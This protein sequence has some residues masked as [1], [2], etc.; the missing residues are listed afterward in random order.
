[1]MAVIAMFGDSAGVIYLSGDGRSKMTYAGGKAGA[2]VYQQIINQIPPHE[3]Y[4]EPFLGGG[5]VL[6]A[7]KR[8]ACSI[9]LDVDAAVVERWSRLN[10]DLVFGPRVPGLTVITG[11]AISYLQNQRCG[12]ETFVYCDPPYLF[13]V[14]SSK[15]RIYTHEFGDV[16]QHEKLL[17]VL[18]SLPCMVAVS[19]YWSSLYESSLPATEGWRSIS[20]NAK[21]RAGVAREWLWMNYPE[22][23][24]LHDYSYLGQNFRE[25]EKIT[26]QKK[27]WRARLL[28]MDKLQR[29]ALLS[30]IAELDLSAD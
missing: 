24:E 6:L 4:I 29:Y 18:K 20:F 13:D 8:A 11:D 10:D 26:R 12:P 14:R 7:K 28:R 2:G 27:R 5:A 19:G 22:P 17:A 1:M 9:A 30:S 16:G 23:V 3:V 15:G 25:R 21:T